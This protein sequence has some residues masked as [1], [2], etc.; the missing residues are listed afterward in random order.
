MRFI[1]NDGGSRDIVLC[2]GHRRAFSNSQ[3]PGTHGF[4]VVE[5]CAIQEQAE[6]VDHDA[7]SMKKAR[8]IMPSVIQYR[9]DLPLFELSRVISIP[10]RSTLICT[11]YCVRSKEHYEKPTEAL[12]PALAYVEF[13]WPSDL[14]IRWPAF[15]FL[16]QI[17]VSFFC[18]RFVIVKGKHFDNS[19]RF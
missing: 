14:G 2:V 8:K 15:L 1:F 10:C 12:V 6:S 4:R 18:L 7:A 3:Q 16:C 17:S 13:R 5:W 11:T 9:M 19:R